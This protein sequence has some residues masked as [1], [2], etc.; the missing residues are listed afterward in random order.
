[1]K[2]CFISE[3][4]NLTC[5]EESIAIKGVIDICKL[6]KIEYTVIHK[7]RKIYNNKISLEK[8]IRK[9]DIVYIFGG[10]SLFYIKISLLAH[11]LKKKI[12]IRP[13]RF[14]EPWALEKKKFIKKIAWYLYQ[15]KFLLQA[16]LV[17]CATQDEEYNIKKLDKKIRTVILPFGIYKKDIKKRLLNRINKRCIF[18]SNLQK[19]KDLDILIKAWIELKNKD[20]CLDIV[21]FRD[22]KYPDELIKNNKIRFLGPISSLY[23][24]NYL[25]DN[26]DFLA[27]PNLKENFGFATLESLSRGVPVLIN[28]K[29]SEMDIQNKNAG[30]VINP[31]IIELRL[32]LYQIFNTK[33]KE[34]FIKRKNAIKIASNFSKEKLSN[35]Y[36]KIYKDLLYKF[37]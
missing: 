26:Y 35:Q 34:F 23:K 5:D 33:N 13:M 37:S 25:V 11:K 10:W 1:M 8:L 14:Y 18:F 22:Q 24:K 15:K 30:W 16:N 32:V 28:D 7:K 6:K 19:P 12:I 4:F 3:F 31:S 9:F 20:W 21:G 17:H 29:T 27:L 2:I 36:F